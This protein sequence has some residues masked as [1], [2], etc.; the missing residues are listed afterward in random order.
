MIKI[1]K[2]KE[3]I[4][5]SKIIKVHTFL[6]NDKKVKVEEVLASGSDLDEFDNEDVIDEEDLKEL[7]DTEHEVFGEDLGEWLSLKVGESEEVYNED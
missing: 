7:T 3:D 1:T 2:E 6:V 5:Y 4:I